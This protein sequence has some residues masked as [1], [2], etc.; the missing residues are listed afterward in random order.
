[1]DSTRRFENGLI[2]HDTVGNDEVLI[3]LGFDDQISEGEICNL[4][5]FD[6]GR[7]Y[8]FYRI[9]AFSEVRP[10]QTSKC[11]FA[12]VVLWPPSP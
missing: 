1:M 3:L 6:G 12:A 4:T 9:E 7:R 11:S 8:E 10:R 2:H 5:G